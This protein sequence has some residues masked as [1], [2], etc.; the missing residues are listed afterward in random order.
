M[1][2]WLIADLEKLS[3][4]YGQGF[5]ASAIPE[6]RNVE[7][8]D[9]RAL[10]DSLHNATRQSRKKGPYHKTRH[11]PDILERIRASVVRTKAPACDRLF[12]TLAQCI[13]RGAQDGGS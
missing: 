13:E 10:E 5:Q 2:A 8:I 11:A 12:V 3:D 1:E 7:Q 9:K 4:Y 6:N